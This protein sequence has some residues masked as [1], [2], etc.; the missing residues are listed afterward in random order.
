MTRTNRPVVS[1]RLKVAELRDICSG[2]GL[3]TTGPKADLLAR[4]NQAI[5]VTHQTNTTITDNNRREE[6]NNTRRELLEE[7]EREFQ[8]GLRQDNLKAVEKAINDGT[9]SSQPISNI[10][11]YLD[12][13]FIS[14]DN[15]IE[16]DE[17][18]ALLVPKNTV[19]E[20]KEAEDVQLTKDELR[21]ARILFYQ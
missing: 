7:Q 11:L 10:K 16:K 1:S 5:E 4:I 15:I 8:E 3:L 18:I 19:I 6:E 20:E 9:C 12:A 17:L 21:K 14:Y 2:M 13:K